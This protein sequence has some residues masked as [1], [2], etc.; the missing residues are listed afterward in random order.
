MASNESLRERQEVARELCQ[1]DGN[2]WEQLE[3]EQISVYLQLADLNIADRKPASRAIYNCLTCQDRG[4]IELEHGLVQV[5]C[6]DCEKGRMM[7]ESMEIAE[8]PRMKIVKQKPGII[9]EG[10]FWCSHCNSMHRLNT[11][12]GKRHLK[13]KED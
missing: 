13:Y 1:K 8:P 7:G 10:M 9:P 11:A 3:E 4:F 6:L 12:I 5:Q 2:E